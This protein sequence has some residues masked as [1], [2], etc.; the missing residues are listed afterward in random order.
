MSS[1]KS[2]FERLMERVRGGDTEA[3]RQLF[4]SY[5]EAIQ[6]VVRRRL[7]RRLRSEFDSLDFVQDAWASF[8]HIPPERFT[9]R[10]PEELVGFLTSLVK[11]KVIDAHRQRFQGEK[12]D[13]NRAEP[14]EPDSS[15]LAVSYPT[16][17]QVMMAEEE[18]ERLIRNKPPLLRRAME[19]LRAG[20]TRREIAEHLG[21]NPKRIWRLLQ[22]LT[23]RVANRVRSQ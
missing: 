7:H 14:L 10:T 22:E 19:M 13:T 3:A 21:L 8:F 5:G 1:T 18:W 9:F 17:S 2:E 20:Y 11:N 15:E 23:E 16:P 12:R 4:E 6:R